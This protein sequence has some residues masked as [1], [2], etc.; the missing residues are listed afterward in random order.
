MSRCLC[1]NWKYEQEIAGLSWRISLEDI[2]GL[3][4]QKGIMYGSKVRSA[5]Y[6][7]QTVVY[8]L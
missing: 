1:R 2:Q 4:T 8:W 7:K 5:D 6:K 3:S